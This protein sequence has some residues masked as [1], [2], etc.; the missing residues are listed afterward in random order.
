MGRMRN[1][2]LYS[3]GFITLWILFTRRPVTQYTE[4]NGNLV[5]VVMPMMY[6]PNAGYPQQMHQQPAYNYGSPYAQAVPAYSYNPNPSQGGYQHQYYPTRSQN[7]Y[8][9]GTMQ[10]NYAPQS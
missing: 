6:P 5:P 9:P 2:A 8:Q 7:Q 1:L 10:S 3:L 4:V